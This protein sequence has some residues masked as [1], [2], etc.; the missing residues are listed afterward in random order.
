[1]EA[2]VQP[3]TSPG[4]PTFYRVRLG[5]YQSLDDANRTKATL[6]QNGVTTSII[7]NTEESRKP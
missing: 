2:G 5:P 6:A 4:K 1:L 7:R 3:V